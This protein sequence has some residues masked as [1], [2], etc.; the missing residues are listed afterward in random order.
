MLSKE[1]MDKTTGNDAWLLDELGI[2]KQVN[3]D[4]ALEIQSI[5]IYAVNEG[6]V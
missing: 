2:D 4:I 5:D 6:D 1:G 3:S